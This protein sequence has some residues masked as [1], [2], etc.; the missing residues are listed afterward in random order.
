MGLIRNAPPTPDTKASAR[1]L[2]RNSQPPLTL[3]AFETCR[4]IL[5]RA[6]RACDNTEFQ[7][8]S[9][10][11]SCVLTAARRLHVLELQGGVSIYA[12]AQY[13]S[14]FISRMTKSE[15]TAFIRRYL[16]LFKIEQDETVTFGHSGMAAFLSNY[17]IRGID[18]SNRTIAMICQAQIEMCRYYDSQRQYPEN[19]FSFL[20]YA[21]RY[22]QYHCQIAMRSCLSLNFDKPEHNVTKDWV[23]RFA[24]MQ[25]EDDWVYIKSE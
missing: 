5:I 18:A 17:R 3:E 4:Q 11:L 15:F 7:N 16:F 12:E 24:G 21:E 25:V 9:S 2:P 8:I 14:D 6:F 22:C 10:A 20:N 13:Q 1:W 19:A 23:N